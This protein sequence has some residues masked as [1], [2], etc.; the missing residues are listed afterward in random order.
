M[1]PCNN[2]VV[3]LGELLG[4]VESHGIASDIIYIN[5]GINGKLGSKLFVTL[6]YYIY[7]KLTVS[8]EFHI[9]KPNP[10]K[11]HFLP[12]QAMFSQ[13]FTCQFLLRSRR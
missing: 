1:L 13:E 7:T 10:I 3:L 11:F 9:P 8:I 2:N 5:D 6:Q 12:N 4:Y